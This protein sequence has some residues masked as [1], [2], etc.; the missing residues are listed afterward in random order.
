LAKL[1][2]WD[3][4]YRVIPPQVAIQLRPGVARKRTVYRV[5][6]AP[7][8]QYVI[9]NNSLTNAIRAVSER[10]FL[11]E[12]DGGFYPP[13][14]G[15]ATLFRR[16]LKGVHGKLCSMLGKRTPISH[17]TFVGLYS[18]R[19]KTVYQA[20]VDSLRID[21]LKDVDSRVKA[22]VKAEKVAITVAKPD[23][24]PR[25]IQPRAPRYNVEV[26]CFLKPIESALY[27]LVDRIMGFGGKVVMKGLNAV[28]RATAMKEAWDAIPDAAV[29]SLDASRFDQ[30][31]RRFALSWEHSVYMSAYGGSDLVKL[32]RLLRRQLRN[33]G[34]VYCEDGVVKYTSDGGRASGDMNTALGNVILMCAMLYSFIKQ[35][36][37][38]FRMIDDGDDCYLVIN[39]AY[40]TRVVPHIKPWFQE[41]GFTMKVAPPV[42]HFP[43]I[44]F[45]QTK[46]IFANGRWV[47]TRL[48]P[49]CISKDCHSLLPLVNRKAVRNFYKSLGDCGLALASGVPILQSFYQLYI[50]SSIGA[51]GF[52][53]HTGLESGMLNLSRGMESKATEITTE[54]RFSFYIAFGY[55]P[56]AQIAYEKYLNSIPSLS[57]DIC[58]VKLPAHHMI[59]L[60]HWCEP[61]AP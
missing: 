7:M 33:K 17:E 48:V 35:F 12:R 21:P 2:G 26:G 20:A 32:R 53:T 34:R 47:L 1:E 60:Q 45:C 49:T 27:H 36:H 8:R 9:H 58:D 31:V 10:V 13:P 29:I 50:R 54:A 37:I 51:K 6:V 14:S 19:R 30:H 46:P 52:G 42:Y 18:G 11:V 24:A 55:P 61:A 43:E 44:E 56:D 59:N 41:M 25:L 4:P 15:N 16:R 38:P 57:D 28:E 5:P 40:I 39:R 23:P 22:F 3:S